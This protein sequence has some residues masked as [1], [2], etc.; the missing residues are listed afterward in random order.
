MATCVETIT[1]GG[2]P[3]ELFPNTL[4]PLSVSALQNQVFYLRT[5]T[6]QTS[7]F[8]FTFSPVNPVVVVSI[9]VTAFQKVGTTYVDLGSVSFGDLVDS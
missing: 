3:P 4:T 6:A 7:V 9:T 8:S 5:Q 2:T 1:G